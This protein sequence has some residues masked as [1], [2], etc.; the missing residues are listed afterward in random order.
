[1]YKN[2]NGSIEIE[3]LNLKLDR[4]R[5]KNLKLRKIKVT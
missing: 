4:N 5:L 3:I 2:Q 1:M